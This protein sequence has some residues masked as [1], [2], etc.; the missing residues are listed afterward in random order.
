MK[1]EIEDGVLIV[2]GFD[3]RYCLV[4]GLTSLIILLC[5]IC[6]YF[7]FPWSMGLGPK[8]LEYRSA[9]L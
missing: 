5:G 9:K 8:I 6:F 4:N 1:T 7:L 3:A 2:K